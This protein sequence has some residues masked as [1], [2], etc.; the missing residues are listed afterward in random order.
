[1]EDTSLG[2]A[3]SRAAAPPT[4]STVPAAS[5]GRAAHADG[6][7]HAHH[8]GADHDH[9]DHDHEHPLEWIELVRIGL[10][11]AAVVAG[12]LGL[13]QSFAS[14]D[15]IA[16]AATLIGGYRRC[17]LCRSIELPALA[18]YTPVKP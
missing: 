10:V 16:L 18:A 5:D 12:W 7:G 3:Q 8:P 11:T 6:H 1:M 4:T 15:G 13:W 17:P 9:E 2:T 14:F